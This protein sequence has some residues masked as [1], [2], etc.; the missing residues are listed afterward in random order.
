MMK[1]KLAFLATT[2][3]VGNAFVAAT[4]SAQSTGTLAAENVEVVVVTGIAGPPSAGVA[5]AQNVDKTRS[6]IDQ[7]LIENQNPGQTILQSLN[8]VPGINFTNSDPYGNAG[9]NIRLRG[10]DGNRVGLAFD[11]MPLNDTGNYATFTN[12]QLDPELITRASVNQGS[13]DVDSPTAAAIGGIINYVSAIPDDV[14]GLEANLSLGEFT[15]N[16]EYLR[17]DTGAF[18]PWDTTAYAAISHTRYEKFKGPGT[19]Q[20]WQFN[21]KVYQELGDRGFVSMAFH[22]NRNRNAFYNNFV[23]LAQFNVGYNRTGGYFENDAACALPTGVNG[24]VQ[25]ENTGA[26][27]VR[28]DGT[29]GTG[30]CTNYAGVRINPS[31]TANVRVNFAYDLTDNILL[32]VDPTFQ[33]V[34]ANGGGFTSISERIDRLDLNITNNAAACL[35]G[36]NLN[37]GIDLNND[38]DSCDTVSIYT[39]SITN[40]RRYG[41]LASLIWDMNESNRFRVSYTNDY[42]RHRQ[43]GE[44]IDFSVTADPAEVYAGKETWG[45]PAL[46]VLGAGGSFYRSRDRYSLAI[47]N[48]LA[49]D[50]FGEF[51]DN[52]LSISLGARAPQFKRELN[53]YCYSQNGSTNV[54][55]T[56]QTPNATLSNGNVTFGGDQTTTAYV[57]PYS[58][59]FSYDKILPNVSAGWDFG[60][61]SVYASYS[62]QIAVP[63]TDNL[64]TVSRPAGTTPQPIAF[65]DVDPEFSKNYEVGYRYTTGSVVASTSVYLNQ[66]SNRVISTLDNDPA[67]PTFNTTIDRNVGKVEATGAEGSI[68]WE[69]SDSVSLYASATY[70]NAELQEDQIV[71]SFTCQTIAPF[72]NGCS[73]A[74]AGMRYALILPTKGKKVVETPDWMYTLRADWQ[75]TDA[76]STGLQAKYVGIRYTTDV[77]DEEVPAYATLDFDARYDLT[78]LLGLRDVYVQLNVT[79]LTDELYPVNISSGTNALLIA[80]VNPDPAIT[81][82]R[83]GAPRTF[84]VAAPRTAVITLGAKY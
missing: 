38:N 73:A 81:N 1:N 33:Y 71:G 47:L 53:Q 51:F 3:L 41:V 12:Q 58:T 45:N 70:I 54:L 84:G 31:D 21:S 34:M 15:Y 18:G 69:A 63:R 10:F 48:Q 24:S 19:L 4:A 72:T 7:E 20:K 46:R 37:G 62:E 52:A 49:V 6:T 42:G 27:F 67:S 8:I 25:N 9:G 26:T 39:P 28:S 13:T 66:Y 50:Y 36:A 40:T 64:Y 65:N 68:G 23:N 80:D 55:C 44:A 43:T 2:A 30:S 56:T 16:R 59:E 57:E 61:S 32:T 22:Y 17:G 77:N 74:T 78:D 82:S 76:L 14:A 35:A 83:A 79:N 29:L 75:V 11:G 5:V 60:D